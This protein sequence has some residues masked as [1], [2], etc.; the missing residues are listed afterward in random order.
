MEQKE[1][2]E[3]DKE[4]DDDDG[5]GRMDGGHPSEPHRQSIFSQTEHP[6]AERLRAGVDGGAGTCLCAVRGQRHTAGKQ[7]GTPAPLRWSG[8]SSAIGE[9]SSGGG[10]GVGWGLDTR[11]WAARDVRGWR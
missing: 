6:I 8:D 5:G 1:S 10:G 9:K 7:R 2:G 3:H 11:R 4:R